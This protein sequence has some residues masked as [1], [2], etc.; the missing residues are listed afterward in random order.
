MLVEHLQKMTGIGL[1]K[2]IYFKVG[3]VDHFA[4]I[5]G[6]ELFAELKLV[7]QEFGESFEILGVGPNY[8]VI[9]YILDVGVK[10]NHLLQVSPSICGEFWICVLRVDMYPAITHWLR[11]AQASKNLSIGTFSY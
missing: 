6:L 4:I 10:T 1:G 5:L 11:R 2:A 7:A 3:P 8:G 9:L